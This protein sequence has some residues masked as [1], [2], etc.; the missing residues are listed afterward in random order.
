LS[1]LFDKGIN[2][3]GQKEADFKIKLLD[4]WLKFDTKW[5][6]TAI[7][8][9]NKSIPYGH[10]PK[11]DPVSSFMTNLIKMD[12]GFV[13]DLGIFLKTPISKQYDLE[14][15][16]TSGGILN[17]P[18]LVCDNLIDESV[19]SVSPRFSLVDYSYNGT[20]MI[21]GRV[22]NQSFKKNEF[23][24]NVVSGR[25][26]NN[27]VVNDFV[28][29]NRAGL[30]WVYKY[31]EKIRIGNQL[32]IGHSNS[33][34]EGSFGT[35]NYQGNADLFLANRIILSTSFACNY[36]DALQSNLYHFNYTNANSL[37]YVLSPH[38]RIRLNQYYTRT[39]EANEDQW[40]VFLQFTTGIGK[41][42]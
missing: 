14:M 1:V 11:L 6:R 12:I 18:I 29:I 30:D 35:I 21:T 33:G 38:S 10:N 17:K 22:G 5:D 31:Q 23:G 40:G 16:L 25:I 27:L 13:Q 37:T 32:I 42:N 26:S 28:T 3:S 2:S 20:W 19:S 4:T 15:S 8:F 34:T 9:G 7:W 24:M 41:R 39:Q 36:H